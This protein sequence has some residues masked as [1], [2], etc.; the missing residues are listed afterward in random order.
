MAKKKNSAAFYEVL[1]KSRERRSEAGLSVPRWMGHSVEPS[2]P[3]SAK[4]VDSAAPVSE[5]IVSTST[6]RLEFSLNYVSCLVAALALLLLLIL[7]FWAGR[8]ST[9]TALIPSTK[10]TKSATPPSP[11]SPPRQSGVRVPGK[12]YLIIQGLQGMTDEH[13][14]AAEKIRQFLQ[15][16]GVE[17]DVA[18]WPHAP[19]QYVVWSRRGFDS[20]TSDE[21]MA[22]VRQIEGLGKKYFTQG[23]NY[24]FRQR[25]RDGNIR[26]WFGQ[27][28][29]Q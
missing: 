12:Y 8:W 24:D 19:K 4:P 6:G 7:A 28:P 16:E 27:A 29:K 2:E 1:S 5:Q 21:A 10:V 9:T 17:C 23:G 13:K 11:P 3:V 15:R 20:E 18:V 22:Y 26:P 25:D 14:A